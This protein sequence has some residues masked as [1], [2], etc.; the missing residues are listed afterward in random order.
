MTTFIERKVELRRT[1]GR[2]LSNSTSLQ[3]RP[4]VDHRLN[5]LVCKFAPRMSF[6]TRKVALLPL[7]V[8]LSTI[9]G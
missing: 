9:S 3:M 1:D 8:G 2:V 5:S 6:T 7:T 4:I